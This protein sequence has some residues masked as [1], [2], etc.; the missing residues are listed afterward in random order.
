LGSE[1]FFQYKPPSGDST[2]IIDTRKRGN[3]VSPI[4]V[5]QGWKNKTKC[6]KN[7]LPQQRTDDHA[8]VKENDY[9]KKDQKHGVKIFIF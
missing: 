9:E 4:T 7:R 8:E 1:S 3:A 5:G 6:F 2:Q